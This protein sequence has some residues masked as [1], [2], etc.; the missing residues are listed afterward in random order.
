MRNISNNIPITVSHLHSDKR[1]RFEN[2]SHKYF[3]LL[4]TIL[5]FVG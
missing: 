4:L 5:I 3:Q 2:Y 1:N